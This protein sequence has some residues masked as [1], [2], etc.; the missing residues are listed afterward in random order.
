MNFITCISAHTI[1]KMQYN[2]SNEGDSKKSYNGLT[3]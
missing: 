3:K 1:L 2:I